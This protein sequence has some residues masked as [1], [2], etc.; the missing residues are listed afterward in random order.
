[1]KNSKK[2]VALVLAMVMIF[3]LTASALAATNSTITVKVTVRSISAA[4]TT[5]NPDATATTVLCSDQTFNITSGS[6]VYNLV[7]TM[8]NTDFAYAHNAA[9]REV[10]VLDS[11]NQPT[12]ETG[13][14]L[15]SLSNTTVSEV[16]GN[17]ITTEKVWG[18]TSQNDIMVNSD[19]FAKYTHGEY[20]GTEWVYTVNG[21]DP[22]VYM[23][24][25][26]LNNNDTVVLT[27]QYSKFSWDKTEPNVG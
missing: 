2:I 8:S 6:S 18:N 22:E 17:T 1:M 7:Q 4:P 12:S 20:E 11:N 9:W 5:S 10:D 24:H 13:Q 14:V 21:E 16:M 3:A 19:M 26:T 25:C 27:Y 15:V 23:D